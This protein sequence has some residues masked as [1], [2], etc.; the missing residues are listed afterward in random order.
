VGSWAVAPL[1]HAI[2]RRAI[3]GPLC[4]HRAPM[5]EERRLR[6]RTPESRAFAERVPVVMELTSRLNVLPFGDIETRIALLG[7]ILGRPLP[8][9]VTIYLPGSEPPPRSALV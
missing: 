3:G 2:V 4:E 8:D 5:P 1:H 6:R 7:E 9:T